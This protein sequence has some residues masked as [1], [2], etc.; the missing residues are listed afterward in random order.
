[1]VTCYATDSYY[2]SLKQRLAVGSGLDRK[3]VA[4]T[5]WPIRGSA[6]RGDRWWRIALPTNISSGRFLLACTSIISVACVRASIRRI[7]NLSRTARTSTDAIAVFSPTGNGLRSIVHLRTELPTRHCG[8]SSASNDSSRGLPCNRMAAGSG[9]LRKSEPG[10]VSRTHGSR[11][12][13]KPT[14]CIGSPSNISLG[15]FRRALR[16]ITAVGIGPAAIRRTS[17]W[18]RVARIRSG[19]ITRARTATTDTRSRR[20]TPAYATA[21]VTALSATGFER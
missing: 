2:G 18:S 1:M 21:C 7:W 4:G 3:T 5:G 8:F 13:S 16:S 6:R 12:P 11:F 15:R 17:S 20:A 19:Q 9:P 14:M 10:M